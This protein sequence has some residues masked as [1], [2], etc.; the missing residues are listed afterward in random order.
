M[1]FRGDIVEGRWFFV[2][3]GEERGCGRQDRQGVGVAAAEVQDAL[4]IVKSAKGV[5]PELHNSLCSD[6]WAIWKSDKIAK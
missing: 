6:R 1:L 5:S 3:D 2:G 4:S